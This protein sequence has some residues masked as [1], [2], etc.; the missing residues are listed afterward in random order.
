MGANDSPVDGSR[1]DGDTNGKQV[2]NEGIIPSN[3]SIK[4]VKQPPKKPNN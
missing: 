3:C 4:K 2:I 1:R